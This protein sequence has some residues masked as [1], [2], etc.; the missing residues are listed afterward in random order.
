[1]IFVTLET[2]ERMRLELEKDLISTSLLVGK[3]IKVNV[4]SYNNFI[5]ESIV[6]D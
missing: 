5:T 1:M 3:N 2:R 4:N 6:D